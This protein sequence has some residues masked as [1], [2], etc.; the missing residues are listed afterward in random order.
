MKLCLPTSTCRQRGLSYLEVLISTLI[1]TLALVPALDALYSGVQGAALL[2][3]QVTAQS[4]LTAKMEQTLAQNFSE[5]QAEADAIGYPNTAAPEPWSDA[6]GSAQR[7]LVYLARYDGDNADG[8]NNAFTGTDAGL[9]WIKVT[10]GG[11]PLALETLI[12]D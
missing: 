3:Q 8:D 5:L 4:R 1:I 9:L 11:T 12:H 2:Q 10:I 7:R 6:A